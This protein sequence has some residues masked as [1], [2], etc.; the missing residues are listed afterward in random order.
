MKVLII[1]FY[2]VMLA[3]CFTYLFMPSP[4]PREIDL[5]IAAPIGG[6]IYW[7]AKELKYW[8]KALRED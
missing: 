4:N 3:I 6:A 2:T 7:S 5:W 8:I 1:F